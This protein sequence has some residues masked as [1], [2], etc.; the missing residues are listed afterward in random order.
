MRHHA[1]P[2]TKADRRAKGIGPRWVHGASVKK[3]ARMITS[4]SGSKRRQR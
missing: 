1:E 3:L 2:T 4:K